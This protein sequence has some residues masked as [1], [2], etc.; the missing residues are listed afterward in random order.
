V[1]KVKATATK[2]SRRLPSLPRRRGVANE[3]WRGL[4]NVARNRGRV[5]DRCL[6]LDQ[7]RSSPSRESPV[8]A[9]HQCTRNL[10]WRPRPV[11]SLT[12]AAM[13]RTGHDLPLCRRQLPDGRRGRGV[14]RARLQRKTSV[15]A[16]CLEALQPGRAARA[17]TREKSEHTRAPRERGTRGARLRRGRRRCA[18]RRRRRWGRSPSVGPPAPPCA[19]RLPTPRAGR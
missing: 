5:A 15:R 12:S 9:P 10:Y 1:N 19:C 16:A 13:R 11:L 2:Y 3:D 14:S 18:R 6:P 4:F 8:H 7:A 17:K